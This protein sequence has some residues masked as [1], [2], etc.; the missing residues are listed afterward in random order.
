MRAPL[1]PRCTLL[2]TAV[3][4][5][6]LVAACGQGA[7]A[8]SGTPLPDGELRIAA[9]FSPRAGYAIDTDDAF[10]LTQLGATEALTSAAADGQVRP[11]L[12]ESWSQIDPLTWRFVL[13]SGVTFHDGTP[14]T[15]A[16]VVTALGYVAGGAAP[17]RALRG[18][19]LTVV[20]D[21]PDAVRIATARP[22]P[23]LPLRMSSPNAVILA[24]SAF[25]GGAP[26]VIGTGT[27]PMRLTA[28]GG[29]P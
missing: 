15:P 24:P 23:I 2:A 10:I 17:P 18:L 12:A 8:P 19:G 11:A 9:Q 25:A 3:T 6:A 5:L 27:G 7:G 28:V 26:S 29:T 1:R 20:E 22:D 13:R 14:V 16:A 21:G 4:V